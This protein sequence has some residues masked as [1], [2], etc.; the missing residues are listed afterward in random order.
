MSPPTSAASS[1]QQRP[2]PHLGSRDRLDPV[3]VSPA[4]ES[5]APGPSAVHALGPRPG[6]LPQPGRRLG[7]HAIPS[8]SAEAGQAR[9]VCGPG[10][11]SSLQTEGA[12]GPELPLLTL[13]T[14]RGTI[15]P[16]PGRPNTRAP[17]FHSPPG[18]GR[19]TLLFASRIDLGVRKTARPLD[20]SPRQVPCAAHTVIVPGWGSV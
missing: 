8:G 13:E 19:A 16:P 2:G 5:G 4:A 15:P 12:S 17:G 18:L 20:S 11:L 10:R 14:S 7:H 1:G 6:A 9:L 3:A